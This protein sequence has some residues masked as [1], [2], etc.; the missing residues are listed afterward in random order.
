MSN[1]VRQREEF[2]VWELVA[3]D[4]DNGVY[5]TAVMGD[6]LAEGDRVK[7]IESAY[8]DRLEEKRDEALARAEQYEVER[9]GYR[10]WL[11]AAER[12]LTEALEAMDRMPKCAGRKDCSRDDCEYANLHTTARS[13]RSRLARDT[14]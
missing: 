1:P 2:G 6:P 7:V 14:E 11:E 3:V 9:D 4:E 5:R 8:A 12:H 10:R 13:I